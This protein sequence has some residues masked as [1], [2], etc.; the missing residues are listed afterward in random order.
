M[1]SRNFGPYYVNQFTIFNPNIRSWI[2]PSTIGA[3]PINEGRAVAGRRE[4]VG[5]TLNP[6]W[7]IGDVAF[8]T[9]KKA[10]KELGDLH[11]ARTKSEY[12]YRLFNLNSKAE[13]IYVV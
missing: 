11:W 6:F 4:H 7:R 9:L 5:S 3:T 2:V 8:S 13:G 10:Q 12:F 1:K